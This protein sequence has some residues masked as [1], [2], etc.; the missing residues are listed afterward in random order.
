MSFNGASWV[1]GHL[2]FRA[3]DVA[4]KPVRRPWSL[5]DGKEVSVLDVGLLGRQRHKEFE[6]LLK[7]GGFSQSGLVGAT[8]SLA[9]VYEANIRKIRQFDQRLP[10][11]VFV[12]K[13][14]VQ[15]FY[16]GKEGP[17]K[18]LDDVVVTQTRISKIQVCPFE[19]VAEGCDKKFAFKNFSF[20][21]PRGS[22]VLSELAF[23]LFETHQ[24]LGSDAVS[25]I[26]PI[27]LSRIL[28]MDH[29][30][31]FVWP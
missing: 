19:K 15:P 20:H 26:D 4:L 24:F 11:M 18:V 13:E 16:K 28:K 29:H 31:D 6:T 14:A 12:A 22:L 2:S 3:L 10:E 25:F 23:H 1:R 21:S 5:L 30:S 7:P 17:L 9:E 8:Q 27:K